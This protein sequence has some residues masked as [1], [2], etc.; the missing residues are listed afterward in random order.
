MPRKTLKH[1][2]RLAQLAEL[3]IAE[4]VRSSGK[5]P[6]QKAYDIHDA[7]DQAEHFSL[8]TAETL[9]QAEAF[10]CGWMQGRNREVI[11]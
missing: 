11:K 3:R 9:A 1:V 4:G 2:R 5:Q 8:Y 7:R 6:E 10:I